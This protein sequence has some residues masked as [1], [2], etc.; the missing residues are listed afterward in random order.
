MGVSRQVL[1]PDAKYGP[2]RACVSAAPGSLPAGARGAAA[3]FKAGRAG[4]GSAFSPPLRPG[5]GSSSGRQVPGLSWPGGGRMATETEG[6]LWT[7]RPSLA[8]SWDATGGALDQSLLVTGAGVGARDF[9]WEEL[10]APPAPGQ[11]PVILKR[12]LNS[13][14]ET[15]CFLYLRCDPEAGEEIVSVGVLSSARNMEVYVAEEYSGTSR[16]KTVPDVLEN[17]EHEI[18]FYKK[19]LKLESPT[20]ACK[21]KLLSFGEKQRVLVS[22]V[23][24]HVGPA[25]ARSPAV[26]AGLDLQRVQT[27]VRSMGSTLS[28]GAQQLMSMVSFQ[29]QNCISI[30]EQL[31]SVLGKTAFTQM[32]GLQ[33]LC[34]SAAWDGSPSTPSPFRAGLTP[35]RVTGGSEAH[36]DSSTQPAA[37]GHVTDLKGCTAVPPN[38]SLP[39]GDLKNAVSSLLPKKASDRSGAP[40]SELLPLLQSLCSHVNG[41]R[42]GQKAERP[43]AVSK[44]SDGIA[45][46][47]MGEQPVCSYLEK[48][49]TKSMDLLEKRLTDHIDQRVRA[50]QE[51]IEGKIAAL[52]DLLQSPGSPAAAGLPL[53]LCDSAERLSNGER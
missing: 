31:Q 30:G 38:H 32:M 25:S 2:A 49:L 1:N 17:S 35:G 51:H 13:P 52:A 44:P 41:L 15:P 37:G 29:Q 3:G 36:T 47:A 40:S 21:I 22:R 8:S 10:L 14:E 23:V 24:A 53:R 34:P 12:S 33:A 7:P 46:V 48:I 26:G 11:D 20:L 4:S 43:G 39:D 6:G 9:E 28:P 45:A 42:G 19:Y 16:G 5:G 27:I 50:L 18:I